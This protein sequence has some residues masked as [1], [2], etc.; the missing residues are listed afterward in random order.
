MKARLWL[1][2]LLACWYA[3]ALWGQFHLN[4]SALAFNDNCYQLTPAENA[5]VGSIW[6]PNKID[7]RQNFDVVM[8]V[9]LG[10]RD[11]GA[12]G[13]VFGLQPVSTS[14]GQVG[15]GIGFGGVSPSLGVEL[16]TYQ[17][18]NLGD[19][20]FDHIA[21]MQNGNLN[22]LGFNNLAGPIRA[23]AAGDDI[24]NC[25]YYD[26]RISWDAAARKLEV[27]FD[28]QLRLSYSGDIV[29]NIFGGNPF[30]FWGFTAATGG[31]NND[32]RV[33]F[34]Y[35]TFLDQLE[36][37]VMCPGG[38]IQLRT[39]GGI[40]YEWT[41]AA[42]L[43]NPAIA[44]PIASPT[45]TTTYRVRITDACNRPFFDEVTISVAG[46]PV[47]FDLGPDTTICTGAQL[48][49]DATTP[50]ASYQ[51]STGDSTARITISE[52]GEYAVT[53]TRR[54][55]VCTAEDALQLS[56][57]PLPSVALGP[58]TSLC[59]GQLLQLVASFP[60]A[61]TL[62][63]DG[64]EG[65]TLIV[66]APGRYLA[67]LFH[68][69]GLV[70]DDLLVS[71]ENC[72]EV[73]MPTVFSPNSDGIN[74]YLFPQHGGDVID[75]IRL[76]VYNRWGGQ[77]FSRSHFAPNEAMQG[78]DGRIDGEPAPAGIYVWVMKILFRDGFEQRQQGEVLLMR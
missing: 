77:V 57:L 45:A 12:D 6:N 2:G 47:F 70:F 29:N 39:T 67:T 61:R 50:T 19:P 44:N 76:E 11:S 53:V 15:E 41:P 22:H 13:M 63:Q 25:R 60:D 46:N 8:E 31:A 38:Q 58:D 66:D 78:W 55:T 20:P 7:L 51:W 71:Y 23:R 30:V 10:C 16:D 5:R 48:V 73:Y 27:Y 24:E 43:S 1:S 18:N 34:S 28:C 35:T 54:D 14:I 9:F 3:V 65:D 21:I 37:K 62:W 74:D 68:P 4:G 40:R 52:A 26:L 49:L 64:R 75:V 69:C 32:H 42:G 72:Q 33:C 36:D 17:N 56:L 59:E